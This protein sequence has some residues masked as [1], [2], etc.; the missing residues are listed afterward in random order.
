MHSLY[1]WS[2]VELLYND[3]AACWGKLCYV[4][5]DN[6]AKFTGSLMQLYKG[7]GIVYHYITIVNSKVNG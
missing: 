7:L 2:A 1:S 5:M 4:Q 6:S 3:V